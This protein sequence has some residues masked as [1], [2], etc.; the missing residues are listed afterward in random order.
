M[1]NR[2]KSN[3]MRG[4]SIVND[5][6][7]HSLFVQL[8]DLHAGVLARMTKLE[9]DRGISQSGLWHLFGASFLARNK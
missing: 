3:Q 1:D 7:I 9:Q 4:R 6:A 2:M 5:S 8:T